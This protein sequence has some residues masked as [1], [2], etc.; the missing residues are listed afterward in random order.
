MPFKNNLPN[1]LSHNQ[2]LHQYKLVKNKFQWGNVN[3][4]NVYL[5]HQNIQMV[6]QLRFR[7][8]F[9]ELAKVLIQHNEKEKAIEIL[10]LGVKLFP[11]KRIPYSIFIPEMVNAYYLAGALKKA[12][13]LAANI[14]N[15]LSQNTEYYT[16]LKVEKGSNAVVNEIRRDLYVLQEIIKITEQYSPN[17]SL[18]IMKV[19]EKYYSIVQ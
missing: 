13:L 12:N 11:G 5:D 15:S 3:Q 14:S 10:D 2:S 6:T 18:E 9:A 1:Q 16:T 4:P 17:L 19:F 8:N 7:Q